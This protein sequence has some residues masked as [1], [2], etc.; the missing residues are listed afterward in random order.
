VTISTLLR[1]AALVVAIAGA[2]DPVVSASRRDRPVVSVLTAS[3]R[4]A[5]LA[6][7]AA[8]ALGRNFT[9]ARR[10]DAGATAV[11]VVGD[12]APDD[13]AAGSARGFALIPA[14]PLAIEALGVSER[15]AL[16]SRVPVTVRLGA[17]AGSA[18]DLTLRV[19]GLVV[20]RATV[21]TSKTG[22]ASAV[23]AFAPTSAG[24]A[25]LRVEASAGSARA[26]ADAATDVQPVR[27]RVLSFDPR[28]SW[29]STFVRRALE[30]D[31]R[32]QLTARVATSPKAAAETGDP[33]A[34]LEAALDGFDVVVVGAPDA[35]GA[36]DVARL[37]AFARAGG[38]VC[39][40]PDRVADGPVARLAG[41]GRWTARQLAAPVAVT[42]GGSRPG[43]LRASELAVPSLQAGTSVLA[44]AGAQ[45][46]VWRSPLGS[47]AVVVSGALDAWRQRAADGDAFATF[48]Q[49]LLGDA[50]ESSRRLLDVRLGRRLF[51]TGDTLAV[52]VATGRAGPS[53]SIDPPTARLDGVGRTDAVRLWLDRP[54]IFVG[55]GVAPS[56]PGVYRVIVRAPPA[57][58]DPQEVSAELLGA[59]AIDAPSRPALLAAW[60]SAHGGAA[61]AQG[62]VDALE[63]ALV[64]AVQ[65]PRRPVREHPMRSPWWIWP[66]GLTLGAEWWLRR[67]RGL[68]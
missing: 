27:W 49:T 9:V 43:S 51:S 39:L 54:G 5:A 44:S 61:I 48:W 34:S 19:N 2:I 28:P 57:A 12:R 8:S 25:R 35:L 33:P 38:I 21:R 60:A 20:D 7:R 10:P 3:R 68:A 41:A 62:D 37:E 55:R 52:R 32:F 13:L 50:A 18:L 40:L 67:R 23:L 4:D 46:L 24:L 1:S 58:G 22:S 16:Q 6:D 11:V 59:D 63:R 31:S 47:G 53:A 66:F 14:E 64:D 15:A 65:P 29:M 45:P 36:A 56:T 42:L 26:A 30:D 17:P